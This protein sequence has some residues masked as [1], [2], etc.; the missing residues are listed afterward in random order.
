MR[1]VVLCALLTVAAC[2][3]RGADWQKPG[4]SEQDVDR[5]KYACQRQSREAALGIGAN[6]MHN[7]VEFVRECMG[8]SGFSERRLE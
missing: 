1:P 6:A 8:K 2:A 3:H 7:Q 5:A 4:A